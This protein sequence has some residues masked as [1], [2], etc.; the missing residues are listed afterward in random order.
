M[1]I[2]SREHIVLLPA[3]ATG[4][5]GCAVAP[6]QTSSTFMN[7]WGDCPCVE[8]SHPQP[9]C[10]SPWWGALCPHRALG[11]VSIQSPTLLPILYPNLSCYQVFPAPCT[12]PRP[13]ASLLQVWTPWSCTSYR[14]ES[15][16]SS[17]P[18]HGAR[19]SPAMEPRPLNAAATAPQPSSGEPTRVSWAWQGMGRHR[20]G[21][22]EAG[23]LQRQGTSGAHPALGS[24]LFS[25]LL[26]G[27]ATR[28]P[29]ITINAE[30]ILTPSLACA[31]WGSRRPLPRSHR[32]SLAGARQQDRA[33]QGQTDRHRCAT[34]TPAGR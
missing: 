9:G 6:S 15:G 17:P 14:N 1:G 4:T 23:A 5:A 33:Q 25:L 10:Q 34:P 31:P 7:I 20:S 21:E 18:S 12:P 11:N 3:A 22:G 24:A 30:S 28:N 26:F 32:A 19:R 13:C 8:G 29:N 27:K 16:Q 2:T